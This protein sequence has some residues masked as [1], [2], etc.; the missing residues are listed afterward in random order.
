MHSPYTPA[1][2]ISDYTS[3]RYVGEVAKTESPALLT[4]ELSVVSSMKEMGLYY[5]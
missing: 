5:A 4:E 3:Y 1:I 2:I